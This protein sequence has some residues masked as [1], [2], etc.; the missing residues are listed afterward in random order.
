LGRA[1]LRPR[2]RLALLDE[3]FRGLD[4]GQRRALL[5]AARETFRAATLLCA[6]H[7]LAETLDFPRVLVLSNGKVVEDGA[8]SEL[9]AREGSH[10]AALL[11]AERSLAAQ[12]ESSRA[13]RRLKI[14]D[15]RLID[16]A[17]CLAHFSQRGSFAQR[18]ELGEAE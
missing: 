1:L 2:P 5:A 7:D 12:F 11:R 4:R 15:G 8:P 17:S 18:A 9:L 16:G 13:W 10:F 14:D 6:T 3:P